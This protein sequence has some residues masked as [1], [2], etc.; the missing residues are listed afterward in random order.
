M[1]RAVHNLTFEQHDKH[2][3]E[4]LKRLQALNAHAANGEDDLGVGDEEETEEL[5]SLDPKEWKVCVRN[6]CYRESCALIATGTETRPLRCAWPFASQIQSNRR[7]DQ[8]RTYVNVRFSYVRQLM[9]CR[10][11]KE[12]SQASS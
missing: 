6:I 1:K 8:D 2:A 5:L 4:E 7:A 10:R 9:L 11:P 3:E 12:G